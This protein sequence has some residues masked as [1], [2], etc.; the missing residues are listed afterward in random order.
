MNVFN[1]RNARLSVRLGAG[2]GALVLLL[3]ACVVFGV[4]RLASLNRGLQTMLA[5]EV[6]A[7]VLSAQLDAQAQAQANALAQ[8]VL[9]DS[10]DE[11]QAQLKLADKLRAEGEQTR[12]ALAAALDTES[13][14]K[15]LQAVGDAEPGYSALL[16]KAAEAIRGG[17]TDT[18]RQHL[19]DKAL[20]TASA[21]Y[22]GALAQL[23]A[24]QQTA[25]DAAQLEAEAKYLLGRN[26]LIA[27]AVMAAVL[28]ALIS[29]WITAS[30]TR[31]ARWAVSAAGRI[32]HGDLTRDI[33]LSGDDEMGQILATMQEMQQSLR[34]VVGSVRS[35]AESV[36]SESAQIAEGNLDLSQRTEHQSVALHEMVASMEQLGDAVK[37]SAESAAQARQFAQDASAVAIKGGDEVGRVVATMRGINDS[38]MKIAEIIAVIDG[39]AF[40]TNIL[41]LNAAVEAARAGEQGRGFAVVA[42][43]VRSLAGRSAE[44]A[45]EIKGLITDS[46]ERV[47]RGTVMVDQA[48]ATMHEIVNS[49][50]RVTDIMTEIN[51]ASDQQLGNVKRVGG[52]VGQIDQVTQQNAALVEQSAAAAESLNERAKQLVQAVAVFQLKP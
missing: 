10:V 35:N 5:F 15:A 13:G 45:K 20:R 51:Q 30:L 31:P 7:S 38:S 47:E 44:A 29:S 21:A 24:V 48:G 52:A 50:R 22:L 28:A 19:N 42:S 9:T 18:A 14:R 3:V 8:A 25:M 2:F 49:I 32:S 37:L 4:L 34:R 23:G 43:E 17:D 6:R 46:V 1:L 16:A 41:A 12:K 40:Q 26:L 39:I 36:S 27:A 33:E 11:I